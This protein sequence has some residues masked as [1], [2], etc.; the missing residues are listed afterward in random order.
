[1]RMLTPN[2]VAALLALAV[3]L[4]L[5]GLAGAAEHGGEEPKILD[6]KRW[7]LGLWTLNTFVLLLVILRVTAWKP[8]MEGLEK[9]EQVIVNARDEAIK[10]KEEAEKARDDLKQQLAEAH[11]QAREIVDEA[12]RDGAALR[13]SMRTEAQAEI[14]AERDR[15]RKEIETAK[16]QAL[17]EI[18]SQSVQLATMMSTKAVRR[19]LSEEDHRRLLD[20]SLAELGTKVGGST[21]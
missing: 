4:I 21:A 11:S 19:E 13:E 10:A 1:M 5:P 18:W 8:I 20:E 6:F 3:V 12:R 16:D 15:L 9:R 7:D 14:Q 2:R 17:Q